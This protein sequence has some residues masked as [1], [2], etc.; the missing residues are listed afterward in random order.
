[1]NDSVD[2]IGSLLVGV[3]YKWRTRMEPR[4]PPVCKILLP[5]WYCA[6]RLPCVLAGHKTSAPCVIDAYV[7]LLSWLLVLVVFYNINKIKL[8]LCSSPSVLLRGNALFKRYE[9]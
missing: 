8:S 3:T 1:M 2:E 4:R 9:S 5:R 6:P 7:G